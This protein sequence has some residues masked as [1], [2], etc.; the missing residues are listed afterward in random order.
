MLLPVVQ[1][2]DFWLRVWKQNEMLNEEQDIKYHGHQCKRE[3]GKVP[4]YRGDIIICIAVYKQLRK[5]QEA[6]S[7]VQNG[8][9]DGPA[10]GRLALLIVNELRNVF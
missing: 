2:N 4:Q 3:L 6:S 8:R 5:R 1:A 9:V 10:L 7:N